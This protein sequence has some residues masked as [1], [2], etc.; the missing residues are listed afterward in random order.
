MTRRIAGEV[1]D[2][3][4]RRNPS[5]VKPWMLPNYHSGPTGGPAYRG[6]PSDSHDKKHKSDKK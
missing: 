6:G 2:E 1:A 3:E 5:K 4:E